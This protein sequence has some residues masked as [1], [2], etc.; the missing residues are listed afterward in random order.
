MIINKQVFPLVLGLILVFTFV[1]GLYGVIPEKPLS[2]ASIKI[3]YSPQTNL[4]AIDTDLISKA[5]KTIDIA[6]YIL[7]SEKVLK[8][9]T[10]AAT[11]GVRVRII[12]DG[13][14]L[15]ITKEAAQFHVLANTLGVEIRVK[16]SDTYDL[17]HLKS[18]VIDN[19]ILRTGAA[20]FS[21]SGLKNQNNDLLVIESI[22]ACKAFERIFEELWAGES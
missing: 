6:A 10:G 22:E 13:N 5:N 7:T 19:K 2:V 11:R 20:N 16:P 18:Y 4:E 14:E 1:K 8:A 9:L 15:P 12:L 17:M 3:R 21:V